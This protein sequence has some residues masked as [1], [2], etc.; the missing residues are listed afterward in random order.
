MKNRYKIEEIATCVYAV[1]TIEIEHYQNR[2]D[3]NLKFESN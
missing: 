3:E 2:F 1:D